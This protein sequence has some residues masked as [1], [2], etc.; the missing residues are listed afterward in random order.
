MDIAIIYPYPLNGIAPENEGE[1]YVLECIQRWQKTEN[2]T[3]Y[4]GDCSPKLLQ[5][6]SI[7]ESV[8]VVTVPTGNPIRG[9]LVTMFTNSTLIIRRICGM[10]KQHDI[11]YIHEKDPVCRAN[12]LDVHPSVRFIYEMPRE[13]YGASS[14]L[15]H[16][17]EELIELHEMLDAFHFADRN[18]ASST[19]TAHNLSVLHQQPCTRSIL[20]GISLDAFPL[21]KTRQKPKNVFVTLGTLRENKR[22]DILINAIALVD[23]TELCIIGDGPERENLERHIADLRLQSRVSIKKK[24]N[25]YAELAEATAFLYAP[26]REPLGL[27]VLQ[28]MAA[29]QCIIAVDDGGYRDFLH[30]DYSFLVPPYPEAFA[31]KISFLRDHPND[32]QK[33]GASAYKHAKQY[34]W[35]KTALETLSVIKECH[36]TFQ[37]TPPPKKIVAH[38]IPPYHPKPVPKIRHRMDVGIVYPYPIHKHAGGSERFVLECIKRWQETQDI[39]L[40]CGKYSQE[41][42]QEYNIAPTVHVVPIPLQLFDTQNTHLPYHLMSFLVN[43]RRYNRMIKQHDIYNVHYMGATAPQFLDVQPALCFVHDPSR[44]VYD[45]RS[46][47]ILPIAFLHMYKTEFYEF[48]EI[49][50]NTFIPQHVVTN[51]AFT[52]RYLSLVHNRKFNN[53]VHPGIDIDEFPVL[54]KKKAV[55]ITVSRLHDAKRLD[56]L[57]RAIAQVD[58]VEFRI[59]GNGDAQQNLE[60]CIAHYHLQD[61]VHIM[62]DVLN[63]ELRVELAQ[64]TAFLCSPLRELFGMVVLEAM[65]GSLPVIAVDEGGYR[66]VLHPDFSFLVPPYP[67]AFAEKIRFFRDNPDVAANM[68]K[69]ARKKS[70]QYTWDKTAHELLSIIEQRYTAVHD[71][72]SLQT[73][74][75]L[76]ENVLPLFGLHYFVNYHHLYNPENKQIDKPLTHFDEKEKMMNHHLDMIEQMGINYIIVHL[77]V[78][79]QIDEIELQNIKTLLHVLQKRNSALRLAIQIDQVAVYRKSIEQGLEFVRSLISDAHYLKWNET[80]CLFWLWTAH[81]DC[82]YD[83]LNTL[84]DLTGSDC[85]HIACLARTPLKNEYV[86]TL[87]FFHASTIYTPLTIS[88]PEAWKQTWDI[89]WNM[90]AKRELKILTV[91]PGYECHHLYQDTCDRAERNDGASYREMW[92]FAYSASPQADMVLLSSFNNF[93]EGTHIEPSQRYQDQYTVA[94]QKYITQW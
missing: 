70:E 79:Y 55:F 39:T 34:T 49:V 75:E 52:A 12:I 41:L 63:E 42:F 35:D 5:K 22:I 53:F 88:E 14:V 92:N 45:L 3:L 6:Y 86:R 65:A 56:I 82:D 77:H 7:H 85:I 48:M 13:I 57:I 21:P 89:S 72:K 94:A 84:R 50:D 47:D 54:P 58:N 87:D 90:T 93:I 26:L 67:E 66:E 91:S 27:P 64:A 71:V 4:C 74:S 78:G 23:N 36:A 46:F 62:N 81:H 40:Y 15:Q 31:E 16:N 37:V 38:K 80:P 83:G 9:D 30:P 2:I 10:L 51:S 29:A 8:H 28:A 61:R 68:G 69:L 25:N 11:Y 43:L 60:R 76:S 73:N 44:Y 20:P 32:A 17:R 1:E 33:M 59:I 18:I 24:L 19:F